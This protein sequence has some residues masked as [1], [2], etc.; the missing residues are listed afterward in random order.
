M[1][2][3]ASSFAREIAEHG[4][5]ITPPVLSSS[6]VASLQEAVAGAADASRGGARNLL[7]H[8]EIRQL[9]TLAPVRALAEVVLGQGAFA[10]RALLF[11]KTVSANW[12]VIWHQD[13]TIAT[14][15]R[16]EVAGYGPWTEKCGVPHVQPPTAVLEA[17]LAV[18]IHLDP[19]GANNGPVRVIGGSHRHGRLDA[20]AVDELRRTERV[21]DCLVE[22]AGVL[23]FRPLLLHASAPATEPHH[24]RVVHI[25]YAAC[26]LATPLQ[27]H[28]R[29][30]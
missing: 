8:A 24:R 9:A 10:V 26:E 18:R 23:A 25:E 28:R 21:T 1:T 12:K 14:K 17:M 7:E 2:F 4:W 30:A 5:A 3:H 11:D 16:A 19:C 15:E 13:I 6:E 20:A 29:V 22:Q 27:W